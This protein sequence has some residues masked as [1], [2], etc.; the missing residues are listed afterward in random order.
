MTCILPY[1]QKIDSALLTKREK[2]RGE[3][4]RKQGGKYPVIQ[5][6]QKPPEESDEEE[7]H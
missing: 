4:L 1:L 5:N 3:V 6:P 2:E 7:E